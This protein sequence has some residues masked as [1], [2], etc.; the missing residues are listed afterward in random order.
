MNFYSFKLYFV[1][2]LL[3]LLTFSSKFC[4]FVTPI[5]LVLEI[6]KLDVETTLDNILGPVD[7]QLDFL[8]S[9]SETFTP[10]QVNHCYDGHLQNVYLDIFNP[11]STLKFVLTQ[12]Y[13]SY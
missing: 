3:L 7:Q 9:L 1:W 4:Y 11:K 13:V 2:F 10:E 6:V 8:L 5:D 12:Y